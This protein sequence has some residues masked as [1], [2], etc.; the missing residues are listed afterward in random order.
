MLKILVKK[1]LSELFQNYYY[2]AKK[3]KAR[4][5]ASLIVSILL[6]LFL[7]VFVLGG[8]FTLLSIGL[9]ATLKSSNAFWIYFALMGA[10][11]ILLGTFGSVFNTYSYLYLPKDNE[12]LISMPIPVNAI[13]ASRLLSVYVMGL[14]YTGSAFIP[15]LIVYW[16]LVSSSVKAIVG[17]LLFLLILS[18]FVL[19]L[20]SA[21]GWV[22]AKISVKLKNKSIITVAI[23]IAGMAGYYLLYYKSQHLLN[24]MIQN[25]SENSEKIKHSVYPFYLFGQA[26]MGE[27]FALLITAIVVLILFAIMWNL[28]SRSFLNLAMTP[29]QTTSKEYREKEVKKRPVDAH[30]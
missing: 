2:D 29:V 23:S 30:F 9:C 19:T 5:K 4:S 28:I 10:L 20:S 16:I 1:Q 11:A 6:L 22:V 25:L 17:G 13:I 18:I 21:L 26:G 3:N 12:L 15:A 8:L 14:L 24:H 27:P 7:L